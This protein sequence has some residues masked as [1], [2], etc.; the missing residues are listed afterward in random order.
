MRMSVYQQLPL[1]QQQIID[2]FI[3]HLW[4]ENGLSENTLSAYRGD[5]SRFSRW[6]QTQSSSLH[7]VSVEHIQAFLA[8]NLARQ[9]KRRSV[10]RLLSTLRRFYRYLLREN[11]IDRDPTHLIEAPKSVQGLPG[12]LNEKQIEDLLAAPDTDDVIG[13]RDRTMLELLYATGLRVS[14]LVG[15]EFSRLSLEPGVLKVVGKGNKERLVPVGE[16]ALHWLGGYLNHVRPDLLKGR[17][18]CD[19]LFV[20][21]RGGG[22]TRQAF[23]YRIKHYARCA[24]IDADKLSPHTLRHA[25]AT[26]LLNH[27]ADLR[28]VQMLLGH[29]DISTTQ[30]YTHVADARLRSLYLQH[31]PRA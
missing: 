29:S 24:G 9:Q 11:R 28:V 17:D 18:A 10:S 2:D 13:F 1:P 12:T 3:D 5:L 27:G 7:D 15:L 20:T 30:I 16:M 19:V 8:D 31:H 6:L 14:E 4:M 21:K 25:F 26:H 23:W 22:M